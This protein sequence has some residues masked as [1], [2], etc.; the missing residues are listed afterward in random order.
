MTKKRCVNKKDKK[1]IKE[2]T[3]M[4]CYKMLKMDQGKNNKKKNEKEIQF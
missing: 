4:V 2:S 1:K 3:R